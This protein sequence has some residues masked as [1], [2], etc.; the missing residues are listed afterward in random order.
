MPKNNHDPLA[1]IQDPKINLAQSLAKL[2][3]GQPGLITP[4]VT[5]TE[6]KVP[7]VFKSLHAKCQCQSQLNT[8]RNK[9]DA[10]YDPLANI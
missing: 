7:R 3:V 6:P 5:Q 9:F 4:L 10:N 2:S 1:N 8:D